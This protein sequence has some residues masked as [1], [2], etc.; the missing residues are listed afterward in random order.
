MRNKKGFTLVELIVSIA[1][2]LVLF[3][4]VVPGVTKMTNQSKIKQCEQVKESILTAVDL[5]VIEH[6]N[7]FDSGGTLNLSTIYD[8]G[9]Y[10]DEEYKIEINNSTIEQGIWEKS[11][12]SS[13]EIKINVAKNESYSGS[14]YS[15]YTYT[16]E[17]DF[18]KQL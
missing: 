1:L 17:T 6:K 14:E 3:T 5:Y 7:S 9:N 12:G 8:G 11:D 2:I 16:I 18:C 10:I 15:Y 4:L 13:Q